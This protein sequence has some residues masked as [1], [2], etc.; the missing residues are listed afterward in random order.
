M[1]DARLLDLLAAVARAGSISAAAR[2]LGISYRTA[3]ERAEALNN[4]ARA[5]VLTRRA[6]GRSGGGTAIT[7]HGREL[8]E[9]YRRLSATHAEATAAAARETPELSGFVATLQHLQLRTSARNQLAGTVAELREGAVNTE[10]GVDLG[11]GLVIEA[12]VTRASA[13][14]LALAPGRAV[15]ALIKAPQVVIATGAA[16]T[17]SAGNC[18]AGTVD[19]IE[20]G[21]VNSDVVLALAGERSLAANIPRSRCEAMGLAP[22]EPAWGLFNASSVILAVV[23]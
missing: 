13:E 18:L 20:P 5:P 4:L 16:P 3:W 21:A 11:A 19:R 10:V 22:G 15:L 23:D 14:A 17:T 6:G 12:M 8:L 9:A 2:E 7:A 1:A